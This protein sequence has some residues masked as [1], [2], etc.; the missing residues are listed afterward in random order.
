MIRYI[1][2]CSALST[3]SFIID[4]EFNIYKCLDLIG[5]REHIVGYIDEEG[6]LAL[7]DKYLQWMGIDP[8][9]YEKC[10][11]CPFLPVCVGGC[12]AQAYRKYG[13]YNKPLCPWFFKAFP[14]VLKAYVISNYS[15]I[16]QS[17]NH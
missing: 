16:I 7:N 15:N 4:P 13:V 5:L 17:L 6:N 1:L 14:H 10:K 9:A 3:S 12:P 11:R 8:S 2:P